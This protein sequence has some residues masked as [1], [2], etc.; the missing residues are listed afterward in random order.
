MERNILEAAMARIAS[1]NL[2]NE[3]LLRGSFL[4]SHWVG[5]EVRKCDDLDFLALSP[6][7]E[8]EDLKAVFDKFC[9]SFR[10][11][12]GQT[13]D[14]GVTFFT[15]RIESE[16]I[17]KESPSPGL[18]LN[19][20]FRF[21]NKSISSSSVLQID[22]GFN[23]PLPEPQPIV[24]FQF[25]TGLIEF[26]SVTPELAFG[27]KLHGLVEWEGLVW[28]AKDLADLWLLQ[29]RFSFAPTKLKSAVRVAFE[30]RDAPLW[31][32]DRLLQRQLG[33]TS[34]SRRRYSRF[35]AEFTDGGRG[36]P[37]KLSELIED[38]AQVVY[39]VIDQLK[40]AYQQRTGQLYPN[41]FAPPLTPKRDR[42]LAVCDNT[43]FKAYS[44]RDATVVVRERSDP[45]VIPLHHAATLHRHRELLLQSEARLSLI[46]I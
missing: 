22:V 33:K 39:P 36:Y 15:K 14:D 13:I 31:R 8:T 19:I 6:L 5:T 10:S 41:P 44:D 32:L 23:D 26:R 7:A 28:R 21:D 35:L 20:P 2:K 12:L 40:E 42:I 11:A 27:W 29:N 30:S 18:R 45:K 43:Y 16:I 3:L 37:E 24:G 4:T 38:V 46:H 25:A 9:K 17:F 1:N 34:G